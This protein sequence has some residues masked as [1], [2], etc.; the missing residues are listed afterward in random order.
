MLKKIF[1]SGFVHIFVSEVINKV[2]IFLSGIVLVRIISKTAYGSFAYAQ[3]IYNFFMI[4]SGLG[5]SS[6]ILQICCERSQEEAWEYYKRGSRW[7][8]GFNFI[9]SILIFSVSYFID[10]PLRGANIYFRFFS[11]LPVVYISVDLIQI[12]NR[13]TLQNRKYSYLSVFST[14]VV[15]GLGIIGAIILGVKGFILFQGLGYIITDIWASKIQ[16]FPIG[17][18]LKKV[19]TNL[20]DWNALIKISLISML[21]NSASIILYNLDIFIL[22]IVM[23]EETVVASYKVA[24]YIPN[25]LSFIPTAL[26]IYV[27]PYFAQHSKDLQWVKTNY[28]R[29]IKWFA[30]FNFLIVTF[31]I[32]FAP[33][34]IKIVFGEQYLDSI[35]IFRILTLSYF[36]NATFRNTT[37]NILASQRR[38]KTNLVI[39]IMTGIINALGDFILIPKYQGEGAAIATLL[40]TVS[41]SIFMVSSLFY[42]LRKSRGCKK[43]NN[44]IQGEE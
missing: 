41:A 10:F 37:G 20:R 8:I 35:N 7:A 14:G 40:V 2:L 11:L 12:Y 21:N 24:T 17:K 23:T 15:F 9:L 4:V 6:G 13:Y 42:Y 26:I 34:I 28:I 38:Y 36:F 5:L 19:N 25:A 43:N 32:V 33:W 39:G 31:L 1:K 30:L 18:L 27:Y 44:G 22:G 16:N 29:L 3:N